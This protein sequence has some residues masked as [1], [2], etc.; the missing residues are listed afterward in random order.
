[1]NAPRLSFVR[2]V[3]EAT[4]VP[5]TGLARSARLLMSLGPD[6]QAIWDRL[7]PAEASALRTEMDRLS[8]HPAPADPATSEA[9]VR[10]AARL[11]RPAPP[12]QPVPDSLAPRQ[13]SIWTRLSAIETGDLLACLDGE[14]PPVLALVCARLQRD[15]AARLITAL[16]VERAIDTLERLVRLRSAPAAILGLLEVHLSA[17]LAQGASQGASPGR[18]AAMLDRLDPAEAEALL[19]GLRERQPEDAARIRALMF[20]F[21]DLRR[22]STAGVQTLLVHLDR[23]LLALALKGA[24]DATQALFLS[25]M[26]QR[27]RDQLLEDIGAL[28]PVR[29]SDIERARLAVLEE[30]RHLMQRGDLS[31]ESDANPDDLVE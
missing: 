4:E 15:A 10:D 5:G 26:T 16:P 31:A 28:G 8:A 11:S 22:L 12:H 19:A 14:P 6:A 21:D 30:V 17:R 29:R 7:A 20:T 24:A 1:M 3:S 23:G 9:F 2:G 18:I 25:N 13:D 27:A